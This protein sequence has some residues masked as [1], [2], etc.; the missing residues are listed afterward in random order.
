MVVTQTS[1]PHSQI[2][3]DVVDDDV[4]VNHLV[5]EDVVAL[6]VAVHL[7]SVEAGLGSQALPGCLAQNSESDQ[8]LKLFPL[9]CHLY[10]NQL[11]HR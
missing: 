11:E 10:Q 6:A 3:D 2:G 8:P 7:S 9:H 1:W 5:V 4:D